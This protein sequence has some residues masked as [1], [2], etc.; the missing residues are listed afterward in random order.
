VTLETGARA[1]DCRI[2]GILGRGRMGVVYRARRVE[3]ARE[4]ALKIRPAARRK[5]PGW[6][7]RFGRD[8]RVQASLE[9]PSVVTVCDAGD[10]E[11][12]LWIA[13]SSCLGSH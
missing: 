3:L 13:C 12:G 9:H 10:S 4:V 6:V 8:G 11:Q 7:A 5:H 2:E 1:A